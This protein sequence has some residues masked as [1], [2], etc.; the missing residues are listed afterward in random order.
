[1]GGKYM[2]LQS[3]RGSLSV[4]L[5]HGLEKA[6]GLLSRS[7]LKSGLTALAVALVVGLNA[8]QASAQTV[9]WPAGIPEFIEASTIL[10]AVTSILSLLIPLFVLFSLGLGAMY[11]IW[12]MARGF[13][14]G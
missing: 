5:R 12:R 14:G 11:L 3:L 13:V 2:C 9:G 6:R 1:M 4:S 8:G 10:E 7:V